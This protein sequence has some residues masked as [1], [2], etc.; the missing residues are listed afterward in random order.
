MPKPRREITQIRAGAGAEIDDPKRV[1]E[2]VLCERNLWERNL[3]ERNLWE[4][5]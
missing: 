2:W 3:W 5:L 1:L 4:R